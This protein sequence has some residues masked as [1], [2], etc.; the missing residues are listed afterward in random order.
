MN[1]AVMV[2]T[3]VEAIT[4][5]AG[6]VAVSNPSSVGHLFETVTPVSPD[7]PLTVTVPPNTGLGIG[8]A[9]FGGKRTTA[10]VPVGTVTVVAPTMRATETVWVT[11]AAV[12]IVT[13]PKD[14]DPSSPPTTFAARVMFPAAAMS[15]PSEVHLPLQERLQG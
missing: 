13:G 3:T 14:R 6:A 11:A 12:V 15:S 7:T 4:K 5:F 2:P 9:E 8:L 1:H 10:V